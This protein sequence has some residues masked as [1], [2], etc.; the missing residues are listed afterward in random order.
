MR[1]VTKHFKWLILLHFGPLDGSPQKYDFSHAFFTCENWLLLHITTQVCSLLMS[2]DE[3]KALVF[4]SLRLLGM[5]Q[6]CNKLA[7]GRL[8]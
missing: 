8:I 3:T 5:Q 2:Q 4:Y 1:L 7:T 6:A